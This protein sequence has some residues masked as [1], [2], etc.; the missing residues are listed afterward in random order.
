MGIMTSG[1]A[2]MHVHEAAPDLAVLKLGCTH[3]LPL[4]E[5]RRFAESV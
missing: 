4:D 1:V 2:F 3:P 5:I